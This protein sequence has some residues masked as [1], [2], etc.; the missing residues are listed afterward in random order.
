MPI[1]T[2]PQPAESRRYFLTDQ[3]AA[4]LLNIGITRFLDLQKRP[5]FPRPIWLGPRG[6]R[7][8]RVPLLEWALSLHE[9]SMP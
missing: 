6:K 8:P 2:A 3:E 4:A 5:D 7:H 9:R 1:K